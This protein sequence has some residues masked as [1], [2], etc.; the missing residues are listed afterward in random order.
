MFLHFLRVSLTY[1][2]GRIVENDAGIQLYVSLDSTQ[3]M[4]SLH[5]PRL[6]LVCHYETAWPTINTQAM[7]NVCADVSH[8]SCVH[9]RRDCKD[10]QA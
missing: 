7:P 4:A 10:R 5:A 9:S 2:T 1:D 3:L 6:P 8:Q